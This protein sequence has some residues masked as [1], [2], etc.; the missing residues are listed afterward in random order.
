MAER[1]KA[2]RDPTLMKALILYSV[3]PWGAIR[4]V[5]DNEDRTRSQLEVFHRPLRERGRPCCG[6]DVDGRFLIDLR[7]EQKQGLDQ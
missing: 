7:E 4:R 6:V 2:K 3:R 1:G 5:I